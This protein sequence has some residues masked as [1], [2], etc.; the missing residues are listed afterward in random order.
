MLSKQPF[1]RIVA[2]LILGII[3][4]YYFS[5]NKIII[6]GALI[7]V[8]LT[9][10]LFS[11]FR[12]NQV[13]FSF[14]GFL[15]PVLLVL[16]GMY[17]YSTNELTF[18]LKQKQADLYVAKVLEIPKAKNKSSQA[19]LFIVSS[20]AQGV[21]HEQNNKVIAYFEQD[22][23]V[24][25][26]LAGQ[27]LLFSSELNLVQEKRN[28]FD[29]D[30]KKYLKH[31]NIYKTVYLQSNEWMILSNRASGLKQIALNFRQRIIQLYQKSGI[32]GEQ[33]AVFSALTLGYKDMLDAKV[34]KAYS[35]AGAMHVLA[36]S[37]LHVGIVLYILKFIFGFFGYFK[38]RVKLNYLLIILG[39]WFYALVTGL[40]TSV[41]RSALMFSFLL[42]GQLIN[43]RLNIYNSLAASAFVLL[44][45]NPNFIFEVGFQLSYIAVAGIVYFQPKIEKLLYFKNVIL[46]KSWSLTAVSL[47]AQL[48]TFPITIYYFHQFPSYFWLSN[49]V[50]IMAAT[51]F[52]I[53]SFMLVCFS[54]F[55]W[56]FLKFGWLLNEFIGYLNTFVY[57]INKLPKAIVSGLSVSTIQVYLIYALIL[58]ISAW[59][60]SKKY[61][62]LISSLSTIIVLLGIYVFNNT[63]INENNK[64]CVYHIP[65]NTAIHIVE[66]KNSNWL[67]QDQK[68]IK[69][70][71]IE[72]ANMYWK[73]RDMDRINILDFDSVLNSNNFL[74]KNNFVGIMNYKGLV[75]NEQV[76][77]SFMFS[78]SKLNIDFVLVCGN[79]KIKQSD[80]PKNLKFNTLIIDGSVPV[81]NA[82][83]W[84]NIENVCVHS[85]QEHGAYILSDNEKVN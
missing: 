39:I 23:N 36:V 14:N 63:F 9:Y 45:V 11:L 17:I 46:Q 22:S 52:L 72:A 74:L 35:G 57:A 80:L 5:L 42:F 77:T 76:N 29:F 78:D 18:S 21:W 7:A 6:V 60:I 1:V 58:F 71:F 2:F 48:S 28:P 27:L 69:D 55:D 34:K 68:L 67:I 4:Q 61:R 83:N 24:N 66:N 16:I 30:Y 75:L 50:V 31:K 32:E 79:T 65:K 70:E 20:Y 38:K 53:S 51:A 64:V 56:I 59:L 41:L 84:Q 15:V 37:G 25:K 10:L 85:T 19:E 3:F 40:S 49:I 13:K 47:A 33:L 54:Y 26:L 12:N 82:K 8:A 62:M 44:F 81:W 73:A 43:K